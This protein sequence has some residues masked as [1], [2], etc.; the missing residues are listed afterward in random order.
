MAGVELLGLGWG[1][2]NFGGEHQR[3]L[4]SSYTDGYLLPKINKPTQ[5]STG[6]SG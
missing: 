6:L 3:V 1:G 4:Q 2:L 5:P